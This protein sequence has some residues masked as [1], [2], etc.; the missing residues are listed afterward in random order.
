ISGLGRVSNLS[1]VDFEVSGG[2]LVGT[3]VGRLDA[4]SV[5]NVQV[6]SSSV[7]GAS[8]VGGL[9]GELLAGA[10]ISQAEVAGTVTGTGSGVVGG[11]VGFSS[12]TL[13]SVTADAVVSS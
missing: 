3:L 6:T 9:V 5:E 12:G 8:S 7:S 11:A 4:G 1:L 13:Q 10:S 2:S